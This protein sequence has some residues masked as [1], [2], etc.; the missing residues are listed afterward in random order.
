MRKR[1]RLESHSRYVMYSCF[2]SLPF[3]STICILQTRWILHTISFISSYSFLLPFGS[4]QGPGMFIFLTFEFPTLEFDCDSSGK[5]TLGCSTRYSSCHRQC[6]PPVARVCYRATQIVHNRCT[7]R[8]PFPKSAYVWLLNTQYL[9]QRFHR[10]SG[11][12]ENL[13][14]LQQSESGLVP[15]HYNGI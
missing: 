12:C 10:L 11:A 15:I 5:A 1:L 2:T 9:V 14:S 7:R 8:S 4:E 13:E 6:A 3:L